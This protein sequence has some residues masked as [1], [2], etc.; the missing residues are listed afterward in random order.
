[1]RGT[2][3]IGSRIRYA[4]LKIIIVTDDVTHPCGARIFV[5][6]LSNTLWNIGQCVRIFTFS[7]WLQLGM[8]QLQ[9]HHLRRVR[10]QQRLGGDL[11][12]MFRLS[13]SGPC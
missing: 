4:A 3:R 2:L 12:M 10:R 1:M 11:Q 6:N 8:E 9:F 13:R 7:A 5:L